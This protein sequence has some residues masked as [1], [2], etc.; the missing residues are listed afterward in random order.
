MQFHTAVNT[1]FT[2]KGS[3]GFSLQATHQTKTNA[4]CQL[5]DTKP[6]DRFLL[7]LLAVLCDLNL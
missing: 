1:P 4:P 5:P 3:S 6:T 7:L 2:W